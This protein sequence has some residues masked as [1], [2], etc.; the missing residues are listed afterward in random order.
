MIV[1]KTPKFA[2]LIIYKNDELESKGEKVKVKVYFIHFEP[3]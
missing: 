2:K 1:T 3:S